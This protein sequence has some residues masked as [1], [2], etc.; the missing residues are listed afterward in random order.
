[1]FH[2]TVTQ[3]SK[4]LGNLSSWLDKAEAQATEAGFPVER[5][6]DARLAPDMFH[7][8]RQVI[9]ACDAAKLGTARITGVEAPKHED[10][11]KTIDELRTRIK[12]T[13]E[14]IDGIDVAA[15]AGVS[16]RLLQIR[17]LSDQDIPAPS[18]FTQ[19]AVPNFHFHLVTAYDILRHNGVK[20][21][22]VDYIGSFDGS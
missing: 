21:G 12:E 16:D 3:M 15:Y 18:Y 19:F 9:S 7:L 6:L 20:I 5:F 11:E 10:N 22:K 2:A 8:T 17:F 1:M 13:R 4:M 14:F